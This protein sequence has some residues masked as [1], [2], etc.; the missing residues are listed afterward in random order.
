MRILRIHTHSHHLTP[1]PNKFFHPISVR[2]QLCRA[3]E[4]EIERVEEEEGV[5]AVG[6]AG[7]VLEEI[8]TG[9]GDDLTVVH[10][11]GSKIGCLP[12]N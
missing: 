3:D 4:G 8:G 1:L 10:G 12:L 2:R 6:G 11:F 9:E 5:A 7:R